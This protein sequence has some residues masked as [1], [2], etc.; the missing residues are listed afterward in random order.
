MG[1]LAIAIAFVDC[2]QEFFRPQA[3]KAKPNLLNFVTSEIQSNYFAKGCHFSC[4]FDCYS[5]LDSW[6]RIGGNLE[7]AAAV[8]E[9][10]SDDADFQG[11]E[12]DQLAGE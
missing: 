3:L 2:Q 4:C 6:E 9:N 7:A 11:I 10:R 5:P 12:M 1:G 8:G